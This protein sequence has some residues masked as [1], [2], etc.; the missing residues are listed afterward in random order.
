[1]YKDLVSGTG[2]YINSHCHIDLLYHR[3]NFY[4][5][6]ADIKK[7]HQDTFDQNN[8]V[9]AIH[10]D[11]GRTFYLKKE[12]GG[13]QRL[14]RSVEGA[15]AMVSSFPKLLCW[16]FTSATS[17]H[18]VAKK[19][20]LQRLLLET[21]APYFVPQYIPHDMHKYSTPGMAITGLLLLSLHEFSIV[22]MNFLEVDML[23]I[24]GIQLATS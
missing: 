12:F 20:P 5:S 17:V 15:R 8:E 21:D 3:T 13:L 18:E 19:L 10:I 9:F 6:W 23:H 14:H 24:S 1:L 2:T 16:S 7:I 11:F 22:C 4:G